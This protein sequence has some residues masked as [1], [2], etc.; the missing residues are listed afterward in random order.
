LGLLGAI[1]I[2]SGLILLGKKRVKNKSVNQAMFDRQL[3][4]TWRS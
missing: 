1:G 4:T 2:F 3:K